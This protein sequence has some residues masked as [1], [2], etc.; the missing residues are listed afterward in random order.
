M[1]VRAQ[2]VFRDLA[3]DVGKA[4]V[5]G[6]EERVS[7]KFFVRMAGQKLTEAKAKEAVTALELLL[8]SKAT[9]PGAVS[10]PKFDAAA[11]VQGKGRLYTLMGE[12][13]GVGFGGWGLGYCGGL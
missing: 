5:D 11:T 12:R 2:G 8:A 1:C 9:A 13:S 4:N 10:R 3:I 6:S 7:D